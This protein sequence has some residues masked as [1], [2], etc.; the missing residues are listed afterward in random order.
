MSKERIV[1]RNAFV[2]DTT[3]DQ[4]ENR[5]VEFVISSEAVDSYRT[6]FKIDGWNLTDYTR[7]PIVCY[8][9]RAN[10]DDPDNIIGTSTVRVENGELIGTV[11]FEDAETNPKA[12]KIFRKV[13][14][15]TLKMASIGAKIEKARFGNEENGEDKEVLYFTEQRLMEWSIVSIGSNPDAHKR[16]A[17]TVAELRTELQPEDV[18]SFD[19]NKRSLREAELLVNN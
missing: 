11:T 1:L 7:N 4:I 17:Q 9:H 14:S 18:T 13:Q 19:E 15:G 6:V 3:A 2:R 10:S 5:Q 16:N 8:Q 12:E